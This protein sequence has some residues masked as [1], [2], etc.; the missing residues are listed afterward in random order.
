MPFYKR[1]RFAPARRGF[2]RKRQIPRIVRAIVNKQAETKGKIGNVVS[3]SASAATWKIESLVGVAGTAIAQGTNIDNRVGD[4]IYLK[5]IEVTLMIAA[6]VANTGG[7]G[8]VCRFV[9]WHN[10]R[11]QGALPTNTALFSP[12]SIVG[13]IIPLQRQQYTIL[14]DY[15]HSMTVTASNAAVPIAAGPMLVKKFKI[16]PRTKILYSGT[17]GATSELISHDYGIAFVSDDA[18]CCSVTVQANLFFTD[19]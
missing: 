1:Q 6:D 10:N 2:V 12:N 17:T 16:Y 5:C 9:L 13:D 11:C 15:D 3:A 18:N 8:S 4:S 7:N 14:A 19:V